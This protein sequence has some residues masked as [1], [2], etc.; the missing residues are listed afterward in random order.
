M[1]VRWRR[2]GEGSKRRGRQILVKAIIV[3]SN[4]TKEESRLCQ[5]RHAHVTCITISDITGDKYLVYTCT[6]KF[7]CM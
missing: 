2:R 1:G 3:T 6:C 4:H 5:G 7:V